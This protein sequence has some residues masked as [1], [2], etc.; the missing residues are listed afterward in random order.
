MSANK[1]YIMPIRDR[2]NLHVKKYALV[3]KILIDPIQKHAY[4]VEFVMDNERKVKVLAKKEVILSAGAFGTPHLLM[5]SGIGPSEHLQSHGIPVIQDLKVGYN[6]Q[7]HVGTGGLVFVVDEKVTFNFHR[8][9]PKIISMMT[10]FAIK[11]QGPLTSTG[12]EALGFVN[13][14]YNNDTYYPDMEL[15]FFSISL[16]S[17]PTLPFC[18]GID[19]K[20]YN[21]VFKPLEHMEAFSIFPMIL[22]PKSTGRVLLKSRSPFQLPYII[23]NYLTNPEDLEILLEGTKIAIEMGQSKAFKK[24]GARLYNVPLPACK[25][26]GFNS[27]DYWRCAIRQLTLTGYHQSGT[28]KMGP[29]TDPDAVVDPELRVYGVSGLRVID[30]S[31]MPF[32]PSAHTMSPVYMIAEKGADLIKFSYQN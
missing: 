16:G 32:V 5:L 20:L 23:P 17:D 11:N 31:I 19:Q 21:K 14:K 3:T 22:R 9:L 7:D 8:M 30:A 12:I 29:Y 1:A 25:H 6:L 27:D 13:T 10:E 4:G 28:A 2:P 24:Y 26:L 15:Q 18:F